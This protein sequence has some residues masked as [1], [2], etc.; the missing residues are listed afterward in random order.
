MANFCTHCGA[1]LTPETKFCPSCGQSLDAKPQGFP[2]NKAV[3]NLWAIITGAV[4]GFLCLLGF[5]L[6]FV[7][8]SSY[9]GMGLFVSGWVLG[10]IWLLSAIALGLFYYSLSPINSPVQGKALPLTFIG[11]FIAGWLMIL[12]GFA[13][14]DMVGAS[15]KIFLGIDMLM[16]LTSGILAATSYRNLFT[17]PCLITWALVATLVLIFLWFIMWPVVETAESFGFIKFVVIVT[18]L[19][20]AA[21]GA[22]FTMHYLK[23][24]ETKLF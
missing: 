9:F 21:S 12:I 10:L 23:A 3:K 18:P 19:L 15:F 6:G 22:F 20:F 24:P 5:I 7:I 16:F 13:T 17:R 2:Q 1:P 11:L 8:P 14:L 4:L